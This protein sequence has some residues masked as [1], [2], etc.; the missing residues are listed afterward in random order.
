MY[1]QPDDVLLTD[2]IR[3]IAQYVGANPMSA[4]PKIIIT[5][6]SIYIA[7]ESYIDWWRAGG[8]SL[9]NWYDET[10]IEYEWGYPRNIQAGIIRRPLNFPA[11]QVRRPHRPVV[12]RCNSL[13]VQLV[14]VPAATAAV[15][16]TA[17]AKKLKPPKKL[18]RTQSAPA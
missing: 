8:R 2:L 13:V 3:R 5:R 1:A 15:E 18:K 10:P 17:F 9:P 16:K 14:P 4:A 12:R 11:P 7:F 6:S